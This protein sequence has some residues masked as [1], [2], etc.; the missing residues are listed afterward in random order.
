[1]LA[2]G[3]PAP[4][5]SL[6]DQDGKAVD[7]AALRGRWVVLYF[8]PRDDT[9][10]CTVEA[11]EFTSLLPDFRRL[12]ATVLGCSADS[13]AAHTKFIAKH[14]LG[15]TLLTD[16]DRQV[17]QTYGAY[18]KKTLYGK[19]VEGVIRST[20][21]IGP[22]GK[23][24]HHWATVRAAG[25]AEQVRAKLAELRGEAGVP[26][27]PVRTRSQPKAAKAAKPLARRTARKPARPTGRARRRPS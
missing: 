11:C 22:D 3:R 8:Y 9:P 17:M 1:M 25:H 4:P 6:P 19:Q 27:A 21:L 20:V 12:G 15:I 26:A 18:G 23:V 10:G 14:E 24:A 7:L 5:F 13:A 16:A 2:V